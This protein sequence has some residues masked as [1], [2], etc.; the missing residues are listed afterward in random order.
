[1]CQVLR[2]SVGWV[3]RYLPAGLAEMRPGAQMRPEV[4]LQ[5]PVV[6]EALVAVRAVV[7]TAGDA[8]AVLVRDVRRKDL[9]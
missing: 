9:G 7:H 1:M 8:A 6:P 4:P 5:Q 3:I 2:L